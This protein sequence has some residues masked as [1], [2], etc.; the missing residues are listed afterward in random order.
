KLSDRFI[1][2]GALFQNERASLSSQVFLGYIFEITQ[3]WFPSSRV[4]PSIL[5]TIHENHPKLTP[6]KHVADQ[7]E[8]LLKRINEQLN[9]ISEGGETDWIGNLN[10]L[11]LVISGNELHFSQTGTCPAYML[12]K[13]RIRQITDDLPH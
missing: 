7:F 3:P 1:S 8:E 5:E 9:A 6:A 13:N 12:Q 10:G 4:L 11:I 2:S